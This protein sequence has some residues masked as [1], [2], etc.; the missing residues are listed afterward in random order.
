[1]PK[2]TCAQFSVAIVEGVSADS[3]VC[4]NDALMMFG[5]AIFE[6][7]PGYCDDSILIVHRIGAKPSDDD[8]EIEAGLS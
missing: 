4:L 6:F 2:S 3:L 7:Q 1:M 8:L 5:V